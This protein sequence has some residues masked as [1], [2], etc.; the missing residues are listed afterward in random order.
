LGHV[1]SCL[2]LAVLE[3]ESGPACALRGIGRSAVRG[4]AIPAPT[5]Q[6]A[7]VEYQISKCEH[8]RIAFYF[9]SFYFFSF[10]ILFSSVL[11]C[12]LLFCCSVAFDA[13]MGFVFISI[14]SGFRLDMI[15]KFKIILRPPNAHQWS[16]IGDP[17]TNVHWISFWLTMIC[18]FLEFWVPGKRNVHIHSAVS[19]F[20]S[21]ACLPA[22][23]SIRELFPEIA[24][25]PPISGFVPPRRIGGWNF[26]LRDP[27]RPFWD[28]SRERME[29]SL[30]R[31]FG[32]PEG[33]S[34]KTLNP[35]P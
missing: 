32:T 21:K 29:L 1:I 18:N 8:G 11:F 13:Q 5:L 30:L 28:T 20:P 9:L 23:H 6:V 3:A 10:Q 19:L 15:L 16:M 34:F 22:Q 31:F 7:W 24:L 25:F 27:R 17:S 4:P 2:F 26:F 12:S 33:F 14:T 35:K